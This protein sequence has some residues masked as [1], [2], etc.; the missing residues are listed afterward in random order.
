MRIP[1]AAATLGGF[2]AWALSD[3]YPERGR[4]SF[5]NGELFIDL[6]LEET[7]T[8][9]KVKTEVSVGVMNFNKC[10][11]L[12]EF[13]SDGTLVTNEAA[14]LSTEPDGTFVTWEGFDA[15]RVRLTPRTDRPGQFVELVGTPDWVLEVVSRSSVAKDKREL[16]EAY[17]RA[18]VPEYWLVDAR[19]DEVVFQILRRRRDRSVSVAARE[20][21]VRSPV[22]GRGFRLER[23]KNRQ[24]RWS[25]TLEVTPG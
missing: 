11:D 21:W 24:G 4:F 20:G 7:E 25:Y 12:G 3:E 8:H 10:L 2:R 17:H 5:I 23:R 22:F 19:F 9:N 13:Y 16:R 18:G 15:G 14:G 1:A 6:S